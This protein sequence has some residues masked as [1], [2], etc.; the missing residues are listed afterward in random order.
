MGR[1]GEGGREGEEAA[2]GDN[3]A[4]AVAEAAA[5]SI[6]LDTLTHATCNFVVPRTLLL[7]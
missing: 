3:V 1:N 7:H 2:G 6:A 5:G 4:E